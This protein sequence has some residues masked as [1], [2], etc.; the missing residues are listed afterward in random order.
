[1]TMAMPWRVQLILMLVI[2]A[3]TGIAIGIADSPLNGAVSAALVLA[4]VAALH[5]GRERFDV[6]NV[7]SGAG[8]ERTRT[9]YSRATA[10][11]G[12]VLI[13]VIVAWWLVSGIAGEVNETLTV[14]AAVGGLAFVIGAIIVSR[15]G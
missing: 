5:Y 11:A 12:N 1:M 6:I 13:T 9:L 2:A 7:M 8:D 14:L 10:F 3:A 4:F 15:R